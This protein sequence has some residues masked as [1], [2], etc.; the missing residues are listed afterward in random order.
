MLLTLESISHLKDYSVSCRKLLL[1]F[2]HASCRHIEINWSIRV[3]HV[4]RATSSKSYCHC[5]GKQWRNNWYWCTG[6]ALDLLI[7]DLYKIIPV[8][9][10]S[11]VLFETSLTNK[12]SSRKNERFNTRFAFPAICTYISVFIGKETWMIAFDLCPFQTF[13]QNVRGQWGKYRVSSISDATFHNPV[14]YGSGLLRRDS[15]TA[16]L[17]V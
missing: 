4:Q 17:T 10:N 16:V 6:R 3:L 7:Y 9:I 5:Q 14:G 1:V 8:E 15:S 13:H 12:Q 11:E 2:H